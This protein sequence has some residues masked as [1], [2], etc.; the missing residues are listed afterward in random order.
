[1]FRSIITAAAVAATSLIVTA[2][3]AQAMGIDP[4]ARVT[5][6]SQVDG[7]GRTEVRV[8]LDNTASTTKVTGEVVV[9]NP[10]TGKFTSRYQT[11]AKHDSTTL[12]YYLTEA[13]TRRFTVSY[14][15]ATAAVKTVTGKT[16]TSPWVRES[17]SECYGVGKLAGLLY[18]NP[19]DSAK[20]FVT[21][22][23]MGDGSGE[24]RKRITVPANS[25]GSLSV[26]IGG[27]PADTWTHLKSG[28]DV[29]SF[30]I[31]SR[32]C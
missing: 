21:H 5:V 7:S 9:K 1:M 10:K 22:L 2:A 24:V 20:T 26:Q 31:D 27:T 3:P 8:I 17:G 29:A 23:A 6:R 32:P 25:K 28:K 30:F 18:G 13:Q 12:Y 14:F 16:P 19:T 15:D 11:V 4:D